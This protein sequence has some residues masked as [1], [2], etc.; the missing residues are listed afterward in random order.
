M[1]WRSIIAFVTM[2]L[3]IFGLLGYANL[4]EKNVATRAFRSGDQKIVMKRLT[5]PDCLVELFS[6]NQS[7]QAVRVFGSGYFDFKDLDDLVVKYNIPKDKFYIV[8]LT[9]GQTPYIDNHTLE[10]YGFEIKDNAL[11]S[12]YKHSVSRSFIFK[13]KAWLYERE[14]GRSIHDINLDEIKSE[15]QMVAERG[16]HYLQPLN[17]DWLDDWSFVDRFMA[18]FEKLPQDAWVYFH[19]AHGH[20]RT[21]TLLLLYDIYKADKAI[22]LKTILNRQ[23]CLGG[24]DVKD[25]NVWK[26][27]TW[28]ADELKAREKIIYFFYDYMHDPEGYP[29]NSFMTWKTK[30]N[31]LKPAI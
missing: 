15:K 16:F 26:N 24:E 4:Y 20:G 30:Q 21:T 9:H 28:N 14:T 11:S 12:M 22:P 23:Y 31:M 27:G 3:L 10:W 8:D 1:I 5:T 13:M 29:K 7:L 18:I 25:T 17:H 2:S 19:C 6:R